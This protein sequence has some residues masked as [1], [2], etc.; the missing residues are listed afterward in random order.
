MAKAGSTTIAE[1]D[2]DEADALFGNGGDT[3][4]LG[5][6]DFAEAEDLL[7]EVDEDDAEA[8]N[9]TEAGEQISGVIVKVGETRSDF[10][11][12]GEDPMVPTVTVENKEGRFRIIGFASVLRKEL[13]AVIDA[14]TCVPGNLFAARYFGEKPIKRGPYA[15]KNYKHYGV[16]AKA[17]K[18]TNA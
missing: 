16:M 7:D 1:S 18:R 10:A 5:D 6:D 14:G 4:D 15:G 11:A 13:Q 17:R 8:W 3:T 2:L 12:K 9:P